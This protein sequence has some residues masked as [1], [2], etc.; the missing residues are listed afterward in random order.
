[1]F[2][3]YL[4]TIAAVL[5]VSLLSLIGIFTLIIK[6]DNLN[7]IIMFLI[8]LSAGTLLGDSFLHLIP[9]AAAENANLG[10]WLWLLLGMLIFFILEK[11]IH[12]RHCHLSTSTAHPHP[13]GAMN[14]IGD[15]LHNFLDGLAIAGSF[16]IDFRLGL[17]TTVAVVIHEIP[18][19]LSDFAVLLYAGYS[20]T[21]ALLYNFI[22]ATAAVIG[23][24][25]AL[26]IGGRISGFAD[27]IIPFT[28]G[29]FIYIAASDLFPE[30]KKDCGK[31][32]QTLL[33]LIGITAGIGLMLI[34]KK[35]D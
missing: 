15:G 21:K 8:S 25:F 31:L 33:Q 13:V 5:A 18:Q 14:L 29:G 4:S 35:M 10:I 7:K 23:A 11:I 16:L 2:N 24:I 19:E 34:L 1:M 30:L 6:R 27:F 22:S 26:A 28:A 32:G 3:V 17:A 9:E 20:K 12:W